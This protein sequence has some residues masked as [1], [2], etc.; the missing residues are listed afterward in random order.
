MHGVGGVW[1]WVHVHSL[2]L[3]CG[4]CAQFREPN[5][6]NAHIQMVIAKRWQLREVTATGGLAFVACKR[7]FSWHLFHL[8]GSPYWSEVVFFFNSQY[9]MVR[10]FWSR[11]TRSGIKRDQP[12]HAVILSTISSCH[13]RFGKTWVVRDFENPHT[14]TWRKCAAVE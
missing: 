11:R 8:C 2:T 10:L 9:K 13:S 12:L 5:K 7:D 6:P 3:V 4:L 1:F 14:H